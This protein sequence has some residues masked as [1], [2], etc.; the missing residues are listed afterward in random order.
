DAVLDTVD[1]YP[2]QQAHAAFV[3]AH[4]VAQAD[5][6]GVA[7]T[8]F[9][10]APTVVQPTRQRGAGGTQRLRMAARRDRDRRRQARQQDRRIPS[11]RYRHDARLLRADRS[12]GKCRTLGAR[13]VEL[14]AA[15]HE[16][17]TSARGRRYSDEPMSGRTTGASGAFAP[18]VGPRVARRGESAVDR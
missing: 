3:V 10:L 4:F 9:G 16:Y 14:P 15:S 12:G 2:F 6:V 17:W 18:P 11:P 7:L 5:A 1:V 8:P 13:A